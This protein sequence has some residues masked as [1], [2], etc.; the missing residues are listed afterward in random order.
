MSKSTKPKLQSISKST[1][2]TARYT[3]TTGFITA[4][5]SVFMAADQIKSEEV[6]VYNVD[7][8]D[9]DIEYFIDGKRCTYSGF[10]ELYNKL[11]GDNAYEKFNSD[12]YDEFHDQAMKDCEYP[13]LDSLNRGKL[14]NL[15][16]EYFNN[17]AKTAM[18][19]SIEYTDNWQLLNIARKLCPNAIRTIEAPYADSCTPT[20][21]RSYVHDVIDIRLVEQEFP[22]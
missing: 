6:L 18:Y 21:T 11:F 2:M 9:V 14:K 8:S 15:F 13:T 22:L 20:D 4:E 10:K 3:K 17:N 16:R 12:L 1:H 7:I 5:A 19:E